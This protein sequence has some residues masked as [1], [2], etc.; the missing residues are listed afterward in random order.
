MNYCRKQSGLQLPIFK[1]VIPDP[2]HSPG[3]DGIYV[4]IYI[5]H[6]LL[7]NLN[8]KASSA[9]CRSQSPTTISHHMCLPP[10]AFQ[11]SPPLHPTTTP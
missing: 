7:Q 8:K 10:E 4:H 2:T 1:D 5:S 3:I 9:G 6:F 11:L